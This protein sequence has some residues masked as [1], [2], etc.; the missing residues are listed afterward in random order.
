MWNMLYMYISM[1]TLDKSAKQLS[2][3]CLACSGP[4]DLIMYMYIH[5]HVQYTC[6]SCT[7]A[8]E[9]CGICTAQGLSCTSEG[10]ARG[11]T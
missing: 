5:V 1:A 9:V 8:F 6:N 2:T 4:P 10:A 11:S 7:M 3:V